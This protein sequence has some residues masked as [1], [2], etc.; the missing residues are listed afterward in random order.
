MTGNE[1]GI[2]MTLLTDMKFESEDL[3][4]IEKY[5]EALNITD[6]TIQMCHSDGGFCEGAI[7]L[8]SASSI[9]TEVN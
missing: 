1:T 7:F 2:N 9:R 3:E 6:Y 5:A 8:T 4:N